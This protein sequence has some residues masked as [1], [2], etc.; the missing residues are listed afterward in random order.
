MS[1]S[2]QCAMSDSDELN[3]FD[4]RPRRLKIKKAV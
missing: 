3:S 1:K 4:E 2:T